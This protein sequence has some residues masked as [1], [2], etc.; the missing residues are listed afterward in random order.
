MQLKISL[1]GSAQALF[2][3]RAPARGWPGCYR[4]LLTVAETGTGFASD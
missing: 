4:L 2:A 3:P 1:N